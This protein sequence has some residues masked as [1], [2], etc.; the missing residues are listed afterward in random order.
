MAKK[1]K[2]SLL[3]EEESELLHHD[4][5]FWSSR[6]EKELREKVQPELLLSRCF[7]P[8]LADKVIPDHFPFVFFRPPF[9]FDRE[10]W[11]LAG[12]ILPNL[13]SCYIRDNSAFFYNQDPQILTALVNYAIWRGRFSWIYSLT[14]LYYQYNRFDANLFECAA[15]CLAYNNKLTTANFYYKSIKK[16]S[17]YFSLCFRVLTGLD[18]VEFAHSI[19]IE[20]EKDFNIHFLHSICIEDKQAEKNIL[21]SMTKVSG[22]EEDIL[23]RYTGLLARGLIFRANKMLLKYII[24]TQEKS[25]LLDV[26]LQ[27]YLQN[28]KYY[29]YL[30][31]II[32]SKAWPGKR[33]WYEIDYCI[34]RLG[35]GMDKNKIWA[36]VKNKKETIN[37]PDLQEQNKFKQ[38]MA[39]AAKKTFTLPGNLPFIYEDLIVNYSVS[40]GQSEADTLRRH[41]DLYRHLILEALAKNQEIPADV[42][43][44]YGYQ[45]L[46]TFHLY[47]DTLRLSPFWK[48][49]EA[50]TGSLFCT[51]ILMGVHSFQNGNQVLS[52][53]LLS[54]IANP[55]PIVQTIRMKI[56]VENQELQQAERIAA[57]LV[58]RYPDDLSAQFN[59]A[60]ILEKNGK[61]EQAN[62]AYHKARLIDNK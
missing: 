54:S 6:F 34:S 33:T 45:L 9:L 49:L 27:C 48:L 46:W 36:R 31:R 16:P 29:A 35:L 41:Y 25:Y 10:L 19:E 55:H 37:L 3:L 39:S 43:A 47:L 23:D 17:P 14:A 61:K 20:T 40:A 7:R 32:G 30:L 62:Q 24:K 52:E 50:W 59:Y 15:L 38:H 12:E 13:Y 58:K 60:L 42:L 2:F 18:I 56:S 51:R 53:K 57:R 8:S 11:K 26:V 21:L 44:S 28:Q 5:Q 1:V 4:F 22:K